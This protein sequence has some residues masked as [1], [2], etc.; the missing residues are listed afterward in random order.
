MAQMQIADLLGNLMDSWNVDA[1][2]KTRARIER[3]QQPSLPPSDSS[4]RGANEHSP[5]SLESS[6]T[7]QY[8]VTRPPTRFQCLTGTRARKSSSAQ[9][10]TTSRVRRAGTPLATPFPAGSND[11]QT[12]I[13]NTD[14]KPDWLRVGSDITPTRSVQR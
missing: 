3:H 1:G 11:L 7:A 2:V 14:L 13:R 4:L 5:T 6:G 10:A 8:S 9:R 12:W